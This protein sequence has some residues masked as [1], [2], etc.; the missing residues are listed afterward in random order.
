MGADAE[1]GDSGIDGEE[2]LTLSVCDETVNRGKK[3]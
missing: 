2:C 1:I 3:R